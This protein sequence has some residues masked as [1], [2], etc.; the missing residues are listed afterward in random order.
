M[1]TSG[2]SFQHRRDRPEVAGALDAAQVE[3][4]HQPQS[5]DG[6]CPGQGRVSAGET[7]AGRQVVHQ[8]DGQGG[9]TRPEADP[10]APGDEEPAGI[11]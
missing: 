3:P 6:D 11:P 1:A 8:A 10:V 2:I 7:G 5:N 9:D 4:G